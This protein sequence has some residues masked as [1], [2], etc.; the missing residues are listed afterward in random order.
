MTPL[1]RA[2]TRT[3]KQTVIETT[4]DPMV[5]AVP[6]VRKL[7]M[8]LVGIGVVWTTVMTLAH[9]GVLEL[10][11]LPAPAVGFTT[12]GLALA[13]GIAMIAITRSRWSAEAVLDAGMVFQVLG[14]LSV[15][16]AEQSVERPGM[17]ISFVCIWILTF[18]MVPVSPRRAAVAAF[19]SALTGPIA[20]LLNIAIGARAWPTPSVGVMQFFPSLMAAVVAVISNKVVYGLGTQVRNAK[21]LGSYQLVEMLGQ[22]GMGEV[23]RAEHQSLIRPAAVKLL[24]HELATHLNHSELQAMNLRFQR[25]VQATALLTSPH[26]VAV[27]DFGQ[28]NDGNLY[29]VMELLNGLDAESLVKKHGPQPAERVIGI[30]LQASESLA[31]AHYRD[32][33]HRD[34]KPANLFLCAIGMRVDF[35]K[36]LDFGL[37]RDMHSGL[38]LTIDGSV[39]GTPAY[40]APEAAAHNKFDSRGDIYALG[41]VAYWLLTGTLVFEGETAAAVMAAHIRDQ[42]EPPSRRTELPIPPDLEA[43]VMQCLEKDPDKRPQSAVE[44]IKRLDAIELA[45]P[46]T[47][48]RAH[49]WWRTH[50]PDL[51]GKA[52]ATCLGGPCNEMRQRP[53][54]VVRNAA[55]S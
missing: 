27:Y 48:E 8:V 6:R 2:L 34:I 28:T 50:L 17:S 1:D 52:R 12:V 15:S 31:E 29:Y 16:I 39:S 13:A 45:T 18:T 55:G 25:E 44:L 21:Q 5:S 10:P 11:Y 37:V 22:G 54:P 42:P 30:L 38:S 23:W 9:A 40:L 53:A 24:R 33:V 19:A 4:S 49:A 14:A 47:L 20:L 51:L 26:T 41:C 32:L 3:V 46:W 35:V 36:V 43:L 7:A